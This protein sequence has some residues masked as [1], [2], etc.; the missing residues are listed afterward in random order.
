M[1][2]A[3]DLLRR[4]ERDLTQNICVPE[5]VSPEHG[6]MA[7]CSLQGRRHIQEDGAVFGEL[8]AA[9][10]QTAADAKKFLAAHF[11]YLQ[12][13]TQSCK[14]IATLTMALLLPDGHVVV[15]HL[16][17]TQMYSYCNPFNSLEST[18]C[19]VMLPGNEIRTI[20][21]PAVPHYS[22][23][24]PHGYGIQFLNSTATPQPFNP[25]LQLHRI[26]N[27]WEVE[28]LKDKGLTI[29]YNER[30]VPFIIIPMPPP[31]RDTAIQISG[32][33][34]RAEVANGLGRKVEYDILSPTDILNLGTDAMII[35]TDGFE[36]A[37]LNHVAPPEIVALLA[38]PK[39]LALFATYCAG[40]AVRKGSFDNIT[41]LAF[42]PKKP[43]AK[44]F[45]A[46]VIDSS[47]SADVGHAVIDHLSKLLKRP[48]ALRPTPVATPPLSPAA[49]HT[50]RHPRGHRR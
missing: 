21:M 22:F 40:S 25:L 20:E 50:K 4:M 48:Q 24:S 46:A 35:A 8:V 14:G 10:P 39:G 19:T 29:K 11:S 23:Q 41:V 5:I 34:G 9:S 31:K 47:G 42:N 15:G 3:G 30:K 17:D 28:A 7:A 37:V 36:T 49:M 43:P 27:S 18:T 44:P 12:E 16:G 26:T 6:V 32:C 45:L 2:I 38:D 33:I 1:I 13:R